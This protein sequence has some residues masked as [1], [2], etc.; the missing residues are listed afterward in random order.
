MGRYPPANASSSARFR[1][2]S[3]PGPTIDITT[4]DY[5]RWE[6]VVGPFRPFV[7]V[8]ITQMSFERL[9]RT[10]EEE[11]PVST[12]GMELPSDGELHASYRSVQ[13]ERG[14]RNA[15]CVSVA[16]PS[17][18]NSAAADIVEGAGKSDA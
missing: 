10:A 16:M 15:G 4:V 17:D 7:P 8:P 18:E 11:I 13:N 2:S 5:D 9:G 1:S 12:P 3:L 6:F 14:I